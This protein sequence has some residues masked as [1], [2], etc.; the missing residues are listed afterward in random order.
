MKQFSI[1]NQE[2]VTLTEII[3]SNDDLSQE[4]I[5]SIDSLKVGEHIFIGIDEVKR[6]E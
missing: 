3:E 4:D 1:D 6:V 2:S 5:E